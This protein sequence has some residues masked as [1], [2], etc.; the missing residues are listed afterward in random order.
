M[1]FSIFTPTH[2]STYLIELYKS[3]V[4]QTFTDWEWVIVPNQN[5]SIPL[6]IASDARVNIVPAPKA[7]SIKG[8]GALKKFACSHCKGDYLVEVDHDDL[9]TNNALEEID[10]HATESGAGFLYS[11][12]A[13]FRADGTCEVYDSSYGWESYPFF[14]DGKAYTAMKAF[15]ISV[16]SLAQIHFAPN[17]VRV[18]SKEVYEKIGGHDDT[19]R[20]CD[21]FDLI[22]RTYI[23]GV[24]FKHIPMCLYLYRLREDGGNTYLLYNDEIQIL[25]QELSNK[26]FYDLVLEWCRRE[27]LMMLD[28]GGGHN[29]PEGYQSVDLEGGD[30]IHDL[31]T[32]LPFEDN[33]IGVVRAFDFLEHMPHC[34]DSSCDHGAVSRKFCTV[35][36]MNEIHRVLVP[37]GL[38]LSATPSSD[39]RGAFMDPSHT[40]FW[41]PNS[42]WYY[43][44]K[45]FAKYI[46]GVTCRFQDTRIWQTHPSDWHRQHNIPYVYADLVALKDQRQPGLCKI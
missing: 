26:Y 39:G 17:H 34:R 24:P 12:F 2:S 19:L 42:F 13:N 18:W 11:D 46:R 4:A 25:Q 30:I 32:G 43:T 16:S 36:I 28:L 3:L 44:D 9:L 7:I 35:G 14:Y 20:V 1:R 45:N 5:T 40:S 21:D 6:I 31:S 41:S 10:R 27:N 38:L 33:S 29:S 15:P 22:C 37:G 23:E 8:V